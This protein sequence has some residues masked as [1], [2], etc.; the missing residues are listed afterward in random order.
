MDNV[1][2]RHFLMQGGVGIGIFFRAVSGICH[3]MA[4]IAVRSSYLFGQAISP[5]RIKM[6]LQMG[7]ECY[8]LE[9]RYAIYDDRNHQ[10]CQ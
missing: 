3:R 1:T 2:G 4:R 8:D 5:D 9:I 10:K 7:F 6:Y